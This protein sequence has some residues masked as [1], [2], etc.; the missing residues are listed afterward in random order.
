MRFNE[1]IG[2]ARFF[3]TLREDAIQREMIDLA[4]V[5][6]WSAVKYYDE[7]K[8]SE[9]SKPEIYSKRRSIFE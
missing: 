4:L 8:G 3:M 9:T 2:L 6:G 1:Q 7:A 5:Y